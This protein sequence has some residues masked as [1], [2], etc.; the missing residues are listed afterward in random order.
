MTSWNRAKAPAKPKK[1]HNGVL[2]RQAK[3]ELRQ[4]VLGA[5]PG[6]RV[7]DAYCGP[8]GEMHEAVWH[9]ATAYEGCD[10]DWRPTDKRRRY[11]GD[12]QLVM[13]SIDL[14]RFNV[15]D[16]DSFGSPWECSL[17]LAARRQWAPGEVGA[18][19]VTDGSAQ[20]LKFGFDGER[21]LG[22]L[23]GRASHKTLR[24]LATK[25]YASP[26]SARRFPLGVAG[27]TLSRSGCG[28]REATARRLAAWR[29]STLALCSREPAARPDGAET[30]S[31]GRT[32]PAERTWASHTRSG[33]QAN[34]RLLPGESRPTA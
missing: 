26:C 22:Q 21:A 12:A 1:T 33:R 19:V 13:R 27:L 24:E 4:N 10:K 23:V 7:F 20:K 29:C 17:I 11:V 15:F 3:I 6:A 32:R 2:G 34:A 28:P 16:I 31:S 14:G 25:R 5:V 9:A 18:L 8:V 30:V